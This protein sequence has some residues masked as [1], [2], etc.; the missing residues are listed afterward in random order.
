MIV[1]KA[2]YS[3]NVTTHL[4]RYVPFVQHTNVLPDHPVPNSD[5]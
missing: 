4:P 5:R 3:V 2:K 1:V